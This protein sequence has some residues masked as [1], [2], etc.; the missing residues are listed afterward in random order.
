M[1]MGRQ[2][3][4]NLRAST[5]HHNQPDAE[6]VQQ[7]DVIDNAGKVFMF[8]RFAT[9]HDDKRFSP[10][11]IDIGNRMAKSL[12]QLGSTFLYHETTL[13]ECLFVICVFLFDCVRVCK[14]KFSA[15]HRNL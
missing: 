11:G 10:M 1:V 4:I 12:N 3:G 7:A 14:S 13:S 2:V 5:I 9:E 6:A 8:Y 15:K